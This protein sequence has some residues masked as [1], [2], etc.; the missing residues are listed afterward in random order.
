MPST[1]EKYQVLLQHLALQ[2][3]CVLARVFSRHLQLGLALLAPLAAAQRDRRDL[4]LVVHCALAEKAAFLVLYCA[5]LADPLS[6]MLL[7][8]ALDLLRELVFLVAVALLLVEGEG[9][10]RRSDIAG[11]AS[12]ALGKEST[13]EF[14][15]VVVEGGLV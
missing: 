11:E 9:R 12:R 15:N 6:G 2:T 8:E 4:E 5:V 13:F 10:V 3:P 7:N 1:T 14:L